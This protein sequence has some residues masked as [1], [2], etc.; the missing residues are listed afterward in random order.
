MAQRERWGKKNFEDKRD[1]KT[2]NEHLIKRGEY[3]IINPRFLDNWLD[4]IKELNHRKVGQPYTYPNSM[5]EFL[6]V[7]R[8]KGFDYRALQ[9][10]MRAFS[11]RLGPFPVI[12]FSQIRRRIK[13]LSLSFMAKSNDLVVACDGSGMKVS[14]RGEW[15]RQKWKVRR[16]WIKVVIMGDTDGNI[17]DIR[18]GNEDLDERAASRGMIRR[19]KKNLDKVLLDG[20]H[21]CENTFD[22]CNQA[23]IEPAIKIRENAS[24][25]GFGPRAREVRLYQN[26]GYKNWAEQKGYGMRWPASE[27]VFSAVK[28]IFGEGVQ[29]HKTRNMYHETRLKFWAYQQLKEL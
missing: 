10:I 22:L 8:G 20:Y 16:G 26:L 23:G 7:F 12:S 6:G 9:G 4:E 21:D 18:I 1:W 17:V 29:S 15:I 13:K 25:K 3:Y 24:G 19:N 14:N 28:R 5:I 11:K 27:G 2:Y